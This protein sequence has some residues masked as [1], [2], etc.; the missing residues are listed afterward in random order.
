MEK[1]SDC[2]FF[3]RIDLDAEGFDIFHEISK[4]QHSLNQTKKNEKKK[5]NSK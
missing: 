1:Y 3:H 5:K 2:K 4:I